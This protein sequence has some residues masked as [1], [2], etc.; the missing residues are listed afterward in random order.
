MASPLTGAFAQPEKQQSTMQK[1]GE[2][3]QGFGAGYRGQGQQFLA[4]KELM[5]Q[6]LSEER[7]GAMIADAMQVY[8]L[9]DADRFDD[10]ISLI[11]DR[12]ENISKLGGDPSD[13]LNL[14][15]RIISG[16]LDGA[17]QDLGILLND[18]RAQAYLYESQGKNTDPSAVREY[19]YFDNLSPEAQQQYLTMKRANPAVNLGDRVEVLNPQNPGGDPIATRQRGVSPDNAPMLRGEQAAAVEGAEI[20]AIP[21]RVSAET[22]AKREAE[23]PQA[24]RQL[25]GKQEQLTFLESLIDK[26]GSDSS[27]YTTGLLGSMTK[28]IPGTGAYDLSATV[29]TIKANIGFDKL[30]AMRDASPTGGALGQVSEME[31]RLLQA[32]LGNL[33]TS[34][35]PS[36]FKENLDLV[37]SQINRI[38]NGS[39]E[40]FRQQYGGNDVIS[41]ADRILGL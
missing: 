12:V 13:T 25:A 28:K 9:L 6:S 32:T 37:K 33:E 2:K 18:P 41:E 7:T 22:D 35:S 29:D 31:N 26:A 39:E 8:T 24:E 27:N 38:V 21:Q 4:N 34:Q 14:R 15:Q 10:A 3:L 16:D 19:Q 36:Q 20:A 5:R 1:I 23:R 17:K 30:Q 40:Q 11:D